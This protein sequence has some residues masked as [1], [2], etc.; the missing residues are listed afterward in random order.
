MSKSLRTVAPS[1]VMVVLF[2][3]VI[4]LSIP[5]GPRVFLTISTTELTALMLET[6]YPLP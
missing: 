4:I 3:W 6:I 1:L 2:P 5:L